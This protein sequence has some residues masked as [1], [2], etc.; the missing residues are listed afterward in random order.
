MK[1]IIPHR[2]IITYNRDG[3]IQSNI[4]QYRVKEDG[5]IDEGKILTMSVDKGIEQ[6]KVQNISAL[7]IA[8]VKKGE[9]IK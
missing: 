1:E 6:D 4:L 8:H 7:G 2:L 3:T 5:V 9:K